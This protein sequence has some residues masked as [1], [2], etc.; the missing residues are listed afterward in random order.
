MLMHYV[1]DIDA[2]AVKTD[3]NMIFPNK[4]INYAKREPRKAK[5]GVKYS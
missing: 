1:I 2:D 4:C 5:R 3:M